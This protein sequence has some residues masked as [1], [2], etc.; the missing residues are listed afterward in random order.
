MIGFCAEELK[1]SGPVQVYVAPLTVE[2]NNLIESPSQTGVLSDGV[3]AAGNGFTNTA[4]VSAADVHPFTVALTE[5]TPDIVVSVDNLV[6]FC[7]P[8]L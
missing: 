4:S 8:L 6:G 2:A 3:G 7:W 5:Y 1:L